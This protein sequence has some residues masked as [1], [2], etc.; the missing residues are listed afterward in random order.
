VTDPGSRQTSELE[1]RAL[2][3]IFGDHIPKD[4]IALRANTGADEVEW[5][6]LAM[7]Y[8]LTAADRCYAAWKVDDPDLWQR[9]YTDEKLVAHRPFIRRCL[10]C[11][12]LGHEPT[13]PLALPSHSQDDYQCELRLLAQRLLCELDA[14]RMQEGLRPLHRLPFA[15][16]KRRLSHARYS[17]EWRQL[18][19]PAFGKNRT[20]LTPNELLGR[21]AHGRYE[22]TQGAFLE[23]LYLRESTFANADG[24]T[25]VALNTSAEMDRALEGRPTVSGRLQRLQMTMSL[26]FS[27][28]RTTPFHRNTV[29][30]VRLNTTTIPRAWVIEEIAAPLPQLSWRRPH[31]LRSLEALRD[32]T[33]PEIVAFQRELAV[34]FEGW[35]D[36]MMGTVLEAARLNQRERVF[37]RRAPS[38]IGTSSRIMPLTADRLYRKVPRRF[39]FERTAYQD[40]VSGA[41]H[42][43][44]QRWL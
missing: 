18:F 10:P 41:T 28:Y 3:L 20:Y 25:V 34:V 27:R 30:W 29:A 5:R 36:S 26:A 22:V 7:S 33:H 38:V 11:Y 14:G 4:S 42:D 32:A 44:W 21:A 16:V 35:E 6:D 12:R 43:L 15:A 37:M 2:R 23:P 31:S 19:G 24:H 1:A 40:P 8:T 17:R 13:T 39:A 9:L